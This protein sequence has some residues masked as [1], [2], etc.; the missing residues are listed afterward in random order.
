MRTAVSDRSSPLRSSCLCRFEF[1][2]D[3]CQ[4]NVG[5]IANEHSVTAKHLAP[6][7]R[8]LINTIHWI[9]L[10]PA[11]S[12]FFFSLTLIHWIEIYPVENVIY[13]SGVSIK[14]EVGSQFE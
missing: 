4:P 13:P 8:K 3:V 5:E 6:V 2:V 11:D 9:N 14:F 12:V 1:R 7:V 10:Y